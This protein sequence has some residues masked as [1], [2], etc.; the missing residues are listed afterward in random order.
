MLSTPMK[1]SKQ[2]YNKYF[3]TNWSNIKKYGKESTP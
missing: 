1:K 2:D 3:E